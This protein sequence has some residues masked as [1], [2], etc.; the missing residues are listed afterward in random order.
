[1]ERLH[2]VVERQAGLG[3]VWSV[4]TLRRWLAE[5]AGVSDV[6]V[7]KS[8]INVLPEHLKRRFIAHRLRRYRMI[9]DVSDCPIQS[10]QM[11]GEMGRHM[12]TMPRA[13]ALAVVT[14][15]SLARMQVR[16]LFTQ[17]YVRITATVEE[18]RAWV[19]SRIEPT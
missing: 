2:A 8:Y 19:L 5:Q 9:I 12:A 7:L 15:S 4:E 17:S 14:G 10:Q 1:M 16:R 3:N 11:I 6:G 18:G 13:Y